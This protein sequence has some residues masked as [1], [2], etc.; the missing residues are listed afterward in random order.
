MCCI[1]TYCYRWS[2]CICVRVCACVCA[3][4]RVGACVRVCA[5]VVDQWKPTWDKSVIFF[6]H[7]ADHTKTVQWRIRWRCRSWPCPNFWRSKILNQDHFGRLND[8]YLANGDNE[9]I[10][11]LPTYR[12]L[13][14]G[15]R[16][17]YLRLT[18]VHSKIQIQGH[19]N[20][21]CEYLKLWQ[22]EHILLLPILRKSPVG[23]WMMYLH[24]TLAHSKG[25]IQGHAN[26]D[27]EYLVNGDR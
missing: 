25:P 3:C 15:F 11:L 20:F 4:V 10:L 14:I 2:V 9:Q 26:F 16:L 8:G 6:H 13:L 21:D 19:A 24:L 7:L 1:L 18:V 12:K 22:I 23:Y 5:S 17:V 27:C